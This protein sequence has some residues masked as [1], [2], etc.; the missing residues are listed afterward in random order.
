MKDGYG[1]MLSIYGEFIKGYFDEDIFAC[2]LVISNN[3]DYYYFDRQEQEADKICKSQSDFRNCFTRSFYSQNL[4]PHKCE[5]W[6]KNG[7]L[8]GAARVF[9]D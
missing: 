9:L 1:K 7:F 8:E 3:G 5:G 4:S 2:G 6:I